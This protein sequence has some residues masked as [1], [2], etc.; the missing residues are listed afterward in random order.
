[1]ELVFVMRTTAEWFADFECVDVPALPMHDLDSVF[2]DSHLT[3]INFFSQEGHPS[4]GALLSIT[5]SSTWSRMQPRAA[6]HAPRLGEHTRDVLAEDGYA[7]AEI[8]ALLAS[9]VVFGASGS[10]DTLA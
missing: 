9:G 5:H 2:S 8:G 3:A 6:R 1:M 4:E 7:E 10:G